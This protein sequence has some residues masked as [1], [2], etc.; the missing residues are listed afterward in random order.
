MLNELAGWFK[1]KFTDGP[2]PADAKEASAL[3]ANAVPPDLGDALL[4]PGP[5]AKKAGAKVILPALLNW[6]EEARTDLPPR[7]PEQIRRLLEFETEGQTQARILNDHARYVNHRAGR[8]APS[9]QSAVISP[10][11][12]P[13]NTTWVKR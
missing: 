6:N 12:Y 2:A 4:S 13:S 5:Q 8:S 9:P 3:A 10:G 1:T 11:E 7:S